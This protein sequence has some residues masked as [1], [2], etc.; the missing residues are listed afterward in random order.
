[1]VVDQLSDDCA[2]L[3]DALTF[4]YFDY[5][6]SDSQ[7]P[8]SVIVS[9]LKQVA[10][11]QP[12]L[13]ESVVNLYSNF[14]QRGQLPKLPELENAFLHVCRDFQKTF[15]I[16]DALDECDEGLH[17]KAVLMLLSRLE[18]SSKIR[19]FVTSRPYPQDIRK[20]FDAASQITIEAND[21]D[22]RRFLSNTIDNCPNAD[23]IDDVFRQQMIDDIARGAEKL[24]AAGF[25]DFDRIL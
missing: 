8:E 18:E 6:Y 22:L 15:V 9:L 12:T 13:N 11:K 5:Q 10:A 14:T 4:F 17:R 21:L 7:T 3:T 19:L 23:I 25:D 16:I 1:M 20:A 2:G 24:Y